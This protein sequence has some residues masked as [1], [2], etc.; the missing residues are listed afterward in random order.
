MQNLLGAAASLLLVF[1]EAL[2]LSIHHSGEPK[3]HIKNGTIVGK[4]VDSYAQDLFLG[5]PFA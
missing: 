3:V 1:P 5:I 2:A 4:R